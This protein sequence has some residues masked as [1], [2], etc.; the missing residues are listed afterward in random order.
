MT[1][2]YCHLFSWSFRY[3]N[4]TKTVKY[5]CGYLFADT[6]LSDSIIGLI[7]LFSSIGLLVICLIILVKMLNS[8]LKEKLAKT[9]TKTINSD[10]PYVPWLTGYVIMDLVLFGW[11]NPNNF[12]SGTWWLF[13]VLW[14]HFWYNPLQY[15]LPQ[16]HLWLGLEFSLWKEHI[17]WL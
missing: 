6:G 11:T 8:L 17:H 13:L 12:V 9:V 15:L 10:I 14:L 3:S 1:Y 7:L 16:L 2:I 5:A 4:E